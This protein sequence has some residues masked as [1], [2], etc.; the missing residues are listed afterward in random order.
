MTKMIWFDMDGTIADFYSVNNWLVYLMN[1]DTTPYDNAKPLLNFSQFARY[2]NKIQKQGWKIGIISWG[3]KNATD[4]FLHKIT[5]SKIKWLRA[6]LKSVTWNEIKI[7][8]YGTNKFDICGGGIL[9]DDEERNRNTW[10]N[11]AFSPS[12]IIS[13]LKGI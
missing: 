9:F 2:L 3:S 1:E 8:P 13:V 7:V 10:G 6:H 12:E 5:I 11:N 4:D